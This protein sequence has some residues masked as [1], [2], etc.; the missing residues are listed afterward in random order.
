MSWDLLRTIFEGEVF[1]GSFSATGRP[2]ATLSTF[3]LRHPH[4]FR[5][6]TL[7]L[8]A[9]VLLVTSAL[10]SAQERIAFLR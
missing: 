9:D 7:D 6:L 10:A 4:P 5:P 3:S 1:M 2:G 8:D